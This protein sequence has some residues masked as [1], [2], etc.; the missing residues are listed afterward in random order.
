MPLGVPGGLADVSRRPTTQSRSAPQASTPPSTYRPN[1]F[2]QTYDGTGGW[3]A[4]ARL[5]EGNPAGSNNPTPGG[6]IAARP[7]N[8]PSNYVPGTTPP[9][10]NTANAYGTFQSAYGQMYGPE[11]AALQGQADSALAGLLGMNAARGMSESALRSGNAADQRLLGNQAQSTAIQ[12]AAAARQIP[13]LGQMRG[14]EHGDIKLGQDAANLTA[15][16]DR[17][18]ANSDATS[19][20]AM[21]TPGHRD[22]MSEIDQALMNQ[23]LGFNIDADR[24]NTSFDEQEA[25]ARDRSAIL[26]QEAASYGI[27]GQQLRASLEQGLANLNLQ[28]VMDVNGVMDMLASN[29]VDQALVGRHIIESSLGSLNNAL[30]TGQMP[31]FPF[32]GGGG[33][34]SQQPTIRNRGP[35]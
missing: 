28:G 32:L 34:Q 25:Q 13:Y 8:V 2:D 35:Q 31:Q 5:A 24:V 14:Y 21:I 33:G 10:M 12:R 15:S 1:T 23:M 11:L 6:P 7:A 16:H 27:K 3:S 20:G 9:G 29:N 30:V 26:D 22:D 19:R 4:V 17:R 18:M